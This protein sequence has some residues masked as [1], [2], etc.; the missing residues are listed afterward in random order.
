[1]AIVNLERKGAAQKPSGQPDQRSWLQRAP[2][3][4]LGFRPFYLLAACFAALA[5]PLWVLRYLGWLALP[6][7]V[8]LNWHM[9]EMLFGFIV[10]VVIGF[11]YTAGRNWTGLWT[12]RGGHLA[13][14][15]L[16]WLAG[17]LAMLLAPPLVAAV[18][19]LIFLP[20]V[21]WP[22]YRVFKLSAN[23]RNM[24]M[25]GLLALLTLA[26]AVYHAAVLGWLD[27]STMRPLH[28]ALMIV[29][30]IVCVAPS[31]RSV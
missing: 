8:D 27:V 12:P 13:A 11:L 5:V 28:G 21:A 16:V 18:F 17:R 4:A 20:L 15:A 24:V 6:A 26:N 31:Y 19:D 25:V 1:M 3:F 7:N 29:V 9:H 30:V 14:L 22:L 2:V 23:Y 10:T